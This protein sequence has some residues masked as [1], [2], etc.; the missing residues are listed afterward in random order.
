VHLVCR[1]CRGVSE[2][3]PE[4][5][6]PLAAALSDLYDFTTDVGHLTIFGTCG[7]CHGQ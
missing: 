2:V 3:A 1:E 5:I 4:L 7:R 6:D